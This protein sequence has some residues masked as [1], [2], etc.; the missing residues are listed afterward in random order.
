M[1]KRI[2]EQLGFKRKFGLDEALSILLKSSEKGIVLDVFFSDQIL[3]QIFKGYD[4]KNWNFPIEIISDKSLVFSLLFNESKL[5][6]DKNIARFTKSEIYNHFQKVRVEKNIDDY[7]FC[8][9][10]KYSVREARTL[11][12]TIIKDVYNRELTGIEFTLKAY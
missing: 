11:I 1:L 2:L 5:D 10:M 3:I 12:L 7:L 4:V 6:N 8:S 9:P